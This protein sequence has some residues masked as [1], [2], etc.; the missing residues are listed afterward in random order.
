[1]QPFIDVKFERMTRDPSLE[2]SAHRWLARLEA[3]NV[4]IHGAAVTIEPASRRLTAVRLTLDLVDGPPCTA[5]SSHG[6]IYVAVAEA[7]R[8]AWRQ[9]L[10]RAASRG[11]GQLAL[12]AA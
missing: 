9:L 5:V 3:A 4:P 8:A 6:E 10:A 12:R 11:R 7:F 1:M 2:A